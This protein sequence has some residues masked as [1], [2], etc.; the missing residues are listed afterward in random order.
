[1]ILIDSCMFIDWLKQKQPIEAIL[2]PWIRSGEALTCGIVRIE[3]LRG[4]VGP[5]KR[6]ATAI[7]D[8][9]SEVHL[10]SSVLH[11]AS[12]LAWALDRKGIVLPATDIIIAQCAISRGATL[13][14]LD[15][16]FRHVPG[17]K[18]KKELP[19]FR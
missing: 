3:V 4:A 17:L 8:V 11:D 12:E 14:S 19:A 9:L 16:H 15:Q 10:S 13:V 5:V 6:G 1:M 7:F 18:W 2:Q